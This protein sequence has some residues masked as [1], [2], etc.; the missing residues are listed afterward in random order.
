MA[1]RVKR[2]FKYRFPCDCGTTHDRDVN[3]ARNILRPGWPC[4]PVEAV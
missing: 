2:A 3:A 1:Q 4:L